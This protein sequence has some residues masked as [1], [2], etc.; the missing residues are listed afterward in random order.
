MRGSIGATIGVGVQGRLLR[1][2]DK[3]L[4]G[5]MTVGAVDRGRGR[6]GGGGREE[7]DA[8]GGRRRQVGSTNQNPKTS[9]SGSGIRHYVYI[10]L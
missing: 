8:G 1:G 7:E 6:G 9:H 4:R 5:G 10:V 2:V 3:V